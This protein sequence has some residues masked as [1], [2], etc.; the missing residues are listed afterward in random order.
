MISRS[1][2][3]DISYFCSS[4]G[5]LGLGRLILIYDS[6]RISIDGSTDMTFTEDVATRFKA[7]NWHVQKLQQ[8]LDNDFVSVVHAIEK[9]KAEKHRP[10][11]IIAPTTIAYGSLHQGEHKSEGEMLHYMCLCLQINKLMVGFV[12]VGAAHG[13]PLGLDDVKQLRRK[14]NIL[15]DPSL[16]DDGNFDLFRFDQSVFDFYKQAGK[17]GDEMEAKWRQNVWN[18]YKEKYSKEAKELE[19]RFEHRLPEVR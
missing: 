16:D 11:L 5:H 18:V 6:N 14:L 13:A 9:A 2:E 3:T 7:Y 12:L 1:L 17:R 10:S 8:S 4:P 15:S 19:R